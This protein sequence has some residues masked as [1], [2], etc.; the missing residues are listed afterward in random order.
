VRVPTLIT[1][2]AYWVIALPG[3][4]ALGFAGG[5]GGFGIWLALA[6]GLAF[7]AVLLAARYARLT[8]TAPV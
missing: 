6:A 4:Y 5:F 3:G 7:A 1:F 2:V 8:R